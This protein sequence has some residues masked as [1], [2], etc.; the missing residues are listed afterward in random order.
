MGGTDPGV[1]WCRPVAR[2][3]Y[4]PNIIG[5]VIAGTI[6]AT[7]GTVL[8]AMAANLETPV[9]SV[10]TCMCAS[11]YYS[12]GRRLSLPGGKKDENGEDIQM[13]KWS[14]VIGQVMLVTAYYFQFVHGDPP[15]AFNPNSWLWWIHKRLFPLAGLKVTTPPPADT[16]SRWA[17]F[18]HRWRC[19]VPG[20][21]DRLAGRFCLLS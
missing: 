21:A 14:K 19:S 2:E 17:A 18:L 1:A 8:L 5:E 9:F 16:G 11:I 6:V 15:K 7:G 10:S 3:V 13:K 20:Y 4:G 12:V